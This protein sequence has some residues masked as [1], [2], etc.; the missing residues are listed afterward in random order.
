MTIIATQFSLVL[1]AWRVRLRF[2]IDEPSE[3]QLEEPSGARG[4]GVGMDAS[5]SRTPRPSSSTSAP[6]AN[7]IWTN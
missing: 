5:C 7:G 1:G 4:A 6:T 2:D 3:A